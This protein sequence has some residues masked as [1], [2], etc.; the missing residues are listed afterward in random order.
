MSRAVWATYASKEGDTTG[1]WPMYARLSS[2]LVE[3]EG[4]QEETKA[5]DGILRGK[6]GRGWKRRGEG[7]EVKRSGEVA[8][9]GKS[10]RQIEEIRGWKENVRDGG[11]VGKNRGLAAVVSSPRFLVQSTP[12]TRSLHPFMI[13]SKE[14]PILSYLLLSFPVASQRPAVWTAGW[15]YLATVSDRCWQC[16]YFFSHSLSLLFS[17]M[18]VSGESKP[19]KRDFAERMWDSWFKIERV[20]QFFSCGGDYIGLTLCSRIQW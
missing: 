16:A 5:S 11:I 7:K 17:R 19:I 10:G 20:D 8:G 18:G 6:G 15:N 9:R 2:A 14:L 4:V 13:F 12:Q 1:S 3:G